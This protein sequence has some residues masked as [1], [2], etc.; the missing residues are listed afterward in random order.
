MDEGIERM[1]RAFDS[2]VSWAVAQP[3]KA[4]LKADLD[5]VDAVVAGRFEGEIT[6]AAD[7]A[8]RLA[9][10]AASFGTVEMYGLAWALSALAE[11][12][13]RPDGAGR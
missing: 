13:L 6:F 11:D 10:L 7:A 3:N 1:M 8:L 4:A 5:M 9:L 12:W 2:F